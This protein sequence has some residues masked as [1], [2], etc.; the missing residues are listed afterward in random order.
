MRLFFAVTAVLLMAVSGSSHGMGLS[1]MELEMTTVGSQSR[2]QLVV[3]NDSARPLPV[4]L[5]Y[6][7]LSY[8]ENGDQR[9]SPAND[10]L[11]ILPQTAIIPPGAS[12]TFRIQWVANPDIGKSQSFLVIAS[13][14]PVKL[15]SSQGGSHIQVVTAFGAIL[16]V[17]PI[18]GEA[19]LKIVQWAPAKMRNGDPA[20]AVLVENPG[21]VYAL[22]AKASF[23]FGDQAVAPHDIQQHVGYGVVEPGKRRRFL[24]PLKH[25]GAGQA[26]IEYRDVH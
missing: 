14:L 8:T 2:S 24:I 26:T 11:L 22:L 10:E 18:K 19:S 9:T 4:E 15:P 5:S 3:R 7:Q 25:A 17:A 21:N 16:N 12:Q 13:E 23:K 1:P 6:Q 20:A